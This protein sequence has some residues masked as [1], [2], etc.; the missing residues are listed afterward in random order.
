MLRYFYLLFPVGL[1]AAPPESP[2]KPVTDIYHGI[3]VADP[4]RWLE[5]GADKA[6]QKW[7][8]DQNDYAR[9]YLDKLPGTDQ[10]RAK[11][12]GIL[13]EKHTTHAN[14]QFRPGKLFAERRQPPRE[15]PFLVVMP[16]PDKP[17]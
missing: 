12:K 6:V 2:K 14:L 16:G 3:A 8:D 13:S 1:L 17:D 4:Y 5:N 7:S 10:L 11:L 9:A 15:Q